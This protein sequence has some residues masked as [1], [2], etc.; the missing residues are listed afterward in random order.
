MALN[1]VLYETKLGIP[2][3]MINKDIAQIIRN[4]LENEFCETEFPQIK[5]LGQALLP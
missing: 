5:C 3:N 4:I 2:W 1:I